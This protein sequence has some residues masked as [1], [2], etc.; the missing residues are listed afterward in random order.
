MQCEQHSYLGAGATREPWGTRSTSGTLRRRVRSVT[1]VQQLI[2]RLLL[3]RPVLT[4][5]PAGPTLPSAPRAPGAP[6]GPAR[7]LSPDEPRAP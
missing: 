5:A 6:A 7:P 1:E 2:V 3:G 4:A